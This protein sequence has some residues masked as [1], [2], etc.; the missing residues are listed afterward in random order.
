MAE[1]RP[2]APSP[3][4][5]A[6]AGRAGLTP[7]SPL[8]VG[9]L[10][11]GAAVL[12]LGV[13]G[14]AML[15]K[16][17][18][19]VAAACGQGD[20]LTA[21]DTAASQATPLGALLASAVATIGALVVPLAAVIAVAA[22]AAQVAQA[23]TLWIPRR[24][25]DGAPA[26]PADA[27]ARTRKAGLELLH[28]LA[29]GAVVVGWLWWTAPKLAALPTAPLAAGALAINALAALAIAWLAIGVLDAVLR[30]V[31]LG[32]ALR[33]TSAEKREDDRLGASDPRWRRLAR[34]LAREP[35]P[36]A[37][38]A[39]ATLLVLGD[40]A[41]VAIAFDPRRTPTPTR[42]AVGKGVLVTQL[43]A[44]ARRYRLPI[45]REPA[46]A[47]ALVERRGAVPAQH[48]ARLAELVAATRR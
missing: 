11:C 44:L 41:A 23:R 9:A 47:A 3:R 24:R 5:L 36:R 16:L 7:S 35:D 20:A 8:L 42:V 13:L 38:L 45:H 19:Q 21:G 2:F 25:I 15:D 40:D 12:A 29:I 10:A 32:Q 31:A 27:S 1:D 17:G 28:L 43:V 18:A 48:W 30:H 46:L 34:T 6:Q 37:Q 22:I 39:E 4:R 33:M 14:R 26:L